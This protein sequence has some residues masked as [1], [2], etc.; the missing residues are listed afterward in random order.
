MEPC[1]GIVMFYTELSDQITRGYT[2]RRFK[3][4]FFPCEIP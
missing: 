2:G 4:V 3:G 1:N